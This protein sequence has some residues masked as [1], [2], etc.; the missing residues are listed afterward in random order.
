MKTRLMLV[1]SRV[2]LFCFVFNQLNAFSPGS[3]LSPGMVPGLNFGPGLTDLITPCRSNHPIGT[4][5]TLAKR[6]LFWGGTE[7]NPLTF[8]PCWEL[9]NSWTPPWPLGVSQ[10]GDSMGTVCPLKKGQVLWSAL[11]TLWGAHSHFRGK[12]KKEKRKYLED[13]NPLISVNPHSKN[14]NFTLRS[15]TLHLHQRHL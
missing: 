8:C 14:P 13:Y 1:G 3:G 12:K 2:P 5:S 4:Q 15:S 6:E 9:Q 7:G 10:W 11:G